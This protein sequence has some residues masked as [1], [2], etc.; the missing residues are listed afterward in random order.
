MSYILGQDIFNFFTMKKIAY[1]IV[2]ILL[3]FGLFSQQ[4]FKKVHSD[5]PEEGDYLDMLIDND[6]LVFYGL[7]FDSLHRQG[8]R[9]YKADTL[10]NII[11]TSIIVDTTVVLTSSWYREEIIKTLDNNYAIIGATVEGQVYFL[12]VNRNFELLSLVK[13]ETDIFVYN[14]SLVEVEEGFFILS[15]KTQPNNT[16]AM[17][18]ELIRTDI[19]GQEI[20]RK[21]YGEQGYSEVPTGIKKIDDFNFLIYGTY[22]PYPDWDDP[23]WPQSTWGSDY[24]L[25]IDSSGNELWNWHS[26]ST[27]LAAF[28]GDVILMPDSSLVYI[29]GTWETFAGA[30]T[31]QPMI[32]RRDK[33]MNLMWQRKI[34]Y[35]GGDQFLTDLEMT[36]DSNFIASGFARLVD[37][38]AY[39]KG[40]HFKF[41]ADGDS[42][43]IREDSIT[44]NDELKI[45]STE[46]LPSG[47]IF[48][49][50]Y[51]QA[52][53]GQFGGVI[54]KITPDGCVDTLNCFPLAVLENAEYQKGMVYPNPASNTV[55]FKWSEGFESGRIELV[56]LLGRICF[57]KKINQQ[58]EVD[59]SH[60]PKGIYVYRILDTQG[61]PVAVG[62]LVKD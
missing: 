14:A 54:L 25:S 3:S 18:V 17:N 58:Q 39:S 61:T 9:F 47:S 53:F 35:L 5:F 26:D 20:W 62:K 8:I 44:L 6:T 30:Y 33:D 40:V 38:P 48:S 15:F 31:S 60:L 22:S 46:I 4:G 51:Y 16:L 28:V 12:K 2:F 49:I 24:F 59:I 43:W 32:V 37:Y 57:Q 56:D 55:Y 21:E 34:G 13:Y 23:S 36:P 27:E 45:I 50:G 42:I 7:A 11:H 41:S 1:T 29:S 10:G 19:D 52:P